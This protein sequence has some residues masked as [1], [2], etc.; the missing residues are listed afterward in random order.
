MHIHVMLKFKS[1]NWSIDI[2]IVLSLHPNLDSTEL[3]MKK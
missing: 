2:I 1:G 3:L